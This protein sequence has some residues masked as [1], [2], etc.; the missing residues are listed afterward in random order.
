MS[1]G[2]KENLY[3]SSIVDAAGDIPPNATVTAYFGITGTSTGGRN[4]LTPKNDWDIILMAK[5][6]QNMF[7]PPNSKTVKKAIKSH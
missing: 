4:N 6:Q 2:L 5:E 3:S 1:I 7:V